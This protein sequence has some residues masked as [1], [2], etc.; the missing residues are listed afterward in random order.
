MRHTVLGRQGKTAGHRVGYPCSRQITN[1]EAPGE[2]AGCPSRWRCSLYYTNC[3]IATTFADTSAANATAAATTTST[4]ATTVDYNIATPVVT[5]TE[6][7][8]AATMA[9]L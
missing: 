8:G 1:S 7:T 4:I 2:K 3:A 9:T 6:F 5:T